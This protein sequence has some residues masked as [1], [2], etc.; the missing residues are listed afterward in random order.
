MKA[1][2]KIILGEKNHTQQYPQHDQNR[3]QEIKQGKYRKV[4]IGFGSSKVHDLKIMGQVENA[5]KGIGEMITDS[6][7]YAH[8]K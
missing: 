6:A 5:T 8:Q 7:F 2:N 4:M 1:R 3:D